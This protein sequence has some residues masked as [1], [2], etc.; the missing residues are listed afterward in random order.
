MHSYYTISESHGHNEHTIID[1]VMRVVSIL[2]CWISSCFCFNRDT[3]CDL[4]AS[5]PVPALPRSTLLV[6]LLATGVLVL[7]VTPLPPADVAP[8]T[9]DSGEWLSR[10]THVLV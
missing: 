5:D 7:T 10:S 2:T 3:S 9:E 4:M 6:V 1:R 8:V